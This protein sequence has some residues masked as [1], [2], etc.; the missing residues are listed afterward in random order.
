MAYHHTILIKFL[1]LCAHFSKLWSVGREKPL[2]SCSFFSLWIKKCFRESDSSSEFV[3]PKYCRH[4]FHL[5][6]ILNVYF[7]VAS[8]LTDSI[9]LYNWGAWFAIFVLPSSISMRIFL[10]PI[11]KLE[12]QM[13]GPRFPSYVVVFYKPS[14]IELEVVRWSWVEEKAVRLFLLNLARMHLN[15]NLLAE[16]PFPLEFSNFSS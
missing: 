6:C 7:F 14:L 1:S 2:A 9:W 3:G 4:R 11:M 8:W 15:R 12:I 13:R 5:L 16:K 10:F